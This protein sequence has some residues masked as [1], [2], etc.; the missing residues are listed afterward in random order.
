MGSRVCVG[1]NL[2][3]IELYKFIAQFVHKFNFRLSDPEKLWTTKS[4]FAAIQYDFNVKLEAR[5]H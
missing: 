4:Q 5:K 2:A 1:Q 3:L